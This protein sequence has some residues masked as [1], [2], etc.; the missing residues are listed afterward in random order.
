MKRKKWLLTAESDACVST[1]AGEPKLS[2]LTA[3]VLAARGFDTQE[4]ARTFLNQSLEGIH[5]PYLLK[6]MD[7][8]VEEIRR[9]IRDHVKIAVYGDY[10]VDGVTATCI[11]IQYLRAQGADCTYYIPDRLG[12]GYGLNTGA[13]QSLYDDGC[14]LLITVD[15][16]ITAEEEARFA[17]TLG[18]RLIITDHHECKEAL[19]EAVAVV[20]PRR[21]D[22]AYPFRELAGVGVAFKL[23]CALEQQ[24][25][26]EELLLQY[27]DIVAVGTIADVMPL[28]GENRVIV[29]YGLR[30][31]QN[32][33]NQGLKALMQKLGMDA[34]AVT[35]NA[36]SFTM[37]PRINAAG[38]LGAASS[39]ARMF[40]TD[41]PGEATA[42]AEHLCALNH[43]R[44]EE[45]NGIYE[46]IMARIQAHPELTRGRTM[47]LW[48]DGWHNGVIGI[49][50]SR[51]SDRY[52]L[53]CVLISMNGDQGKGSGRSI[54][55]FNLYAA[56]E[57]NA[58]LLEKYGGHE[59]AVGLT[60]RRE[61]L[62]VLRQA[63][64]DYA[65]SG[66]VEDV[67][68]SISVDCRVRPEELTLSEVE[69]LSALEPFG[70]GNPQPVFLMNDVRIEEITPISHDRHVKLHLSGRGRSFY[71][72][73]F[74]MGAKS[75]QFVKGDLLDIVFSA[76]IN[77]YKGNKSVQLVIRDVKWAQRE[78]QA[79]ADALALYRRFREGAQ[80]A[81]Q[82]AAELTPT[83]D[84][85]VAVFRHIKANGEEGVLCASIATLYRKVRYE[86]R[87]CSGMNAGKLLICLDIFRECKIFSYEQTGGEL[88]I[89]LLNY[90]GKADINGSSVLK[91]LMTMLKG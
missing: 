3:R 90:Q 88:V 18:L 59:L 2:R 39:A 91:R 27:A 47:T 52:G 8:A 42:L 75:C 26:L 17:K 60:V 24:R 82:E 81:R 22:S 32:T 36:V 62:E 49:V 76:E 74:G 33:E 86:S 65:Q 73:V 12:E 45:E 37:A 6:D 15:S 7:L 19:P 51:L 84:E 87:L 30:Y 4:K 54:K 61:N 72:F 11:M 46:Q 35:S 16:G 50:S 14:R 5:D 9:A 53:P 71:A 23:I 31:L 78:E 63:L 58:A 21:P 80:L 29:S 70:M 89:R 66:E 69:G 64:E 20:N 85:L 68:P 28:V 67:T 79:D 10:D 56:L 55:G 44:Q 1:L 57:K 77:H 83:R 41:D 13:I 43:R 38:R 25:S 40:L 34:R 48:G